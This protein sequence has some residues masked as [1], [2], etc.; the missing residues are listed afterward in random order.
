M[1]FNK[2]ISVL[3]MLLLLCLLPSCGT[4]KRGKRVWVKVYNNIVWLKQHNRP[5]WL[6]RTRIQQTTTDIET[7]EKEWSEREIAHNPAGLEG[8]KPASQPASK[9]L[10]KEI[11]E[12]TKENE[13]H[14]DSEING[15]DHHCTSLIHSL[16]LSRSPTDNASLRNAA[17]TTKAISKT[18]NELLIFLNYLSLFK[19]SSHY[20][21][22]VSFS[23]SPSECVCSVYY[24]IIFHRF[25]SN[26]RTILFYW[27]FICPLML[28]ASVHAPVSMALSRCYFLCVCLW[29][30]IFFFWFFH[31]LILIRFLCEIMLRR[32][33]EHWIVV[34]CT[35]ALTF[36]VWCTYFAHTNPFS[37]SHLLPFIIVR[38]SFCL[39]S[40]HTFDVVIYII[41]FF[42]LRFSPH[43][44][45]FWFTLPKYWFGFA[46]SSIKWLANYQLTLY[47]Q[48]F[49]I[50]N[51][52]VTFCKISIL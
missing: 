45:A 31:C 50:P 32:T 38:A 3:L 29:M 22:C 43:I 34:F 49:A 24:H 4:G 27:I 25:N 15:F 11:A 23:L 35:C 20:Y 16:S 2:S 5:N 14:R 9:R 52:R 37:L 12:Q 17:K 36:K 51:E 21:V 41:A 1:M 26:M 40:V 42:S 44:F 6:W 30:M 33:F 48:M 47:A 7:G 19:P 28:C 46:L 13:V 10:S 39:H 18:N 8:N